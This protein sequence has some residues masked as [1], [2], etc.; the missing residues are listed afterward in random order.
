MVDKGR[1]SRKFCQ[2]RRL[3]DGKKKKNS[4]SVL[5]RFDTVTVIQISPLPLPYTLVLLA[6]LSV[7][8]FS[9]FFRSDRDGI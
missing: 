4:V 6:Y 1:R 3:Q 5:I 7:A 2:E 8:R 9:L